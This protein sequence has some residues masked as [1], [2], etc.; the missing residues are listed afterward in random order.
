MGKSF[1]DK[2]YQ[3]HKSDK[4][5]RKKVEHKKKMTPYKR[6]KIQIEHPHKWMDNQTVLNIFMS[7]FAR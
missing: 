1:N 3:T 7:L 4:I 5:T 6:T 2:S